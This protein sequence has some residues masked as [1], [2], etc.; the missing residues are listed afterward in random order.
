MKH[1]YRNTGPT[2]AVV[3]AVCE[4][5]GHSC[6]VCEAAVGDRRGVDHHI[7][8]RRPR[9][10][11][12]SRRPDTNEPPN[13]MLLCPGCHEDIESNRAVALGAGWLLTQMDDP[14][15]VAVPVRRDQW[16]YLTVAGRYSDSPPGTER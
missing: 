11:G 6:E 1:R 3:E 14:T 8:H 9:A 16:K 4:R 7:H 15:Q 5:A 13:L 2:P 10:A 12:G